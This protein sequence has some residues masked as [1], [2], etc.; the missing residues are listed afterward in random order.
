LSESLSA[1]DL[2]I[3]KLPR[4]VAIIMDGNGRWAT[5]RNLKRIEGHRRGSEVVKKIIDFSKDIGIEVLTLYAFSEENWH[6]PQEEVQAL[7]DI[8]ANYLSSEFERMVSEGLRLHTVG[9]VDK[10]PGKVQDIINAGKKVTRNNTGM[11]FNLALS[12]GSREE[13]VRAVREIVED[14]RRGDISTDDID[15]DLISSHL[16]T[17]D[18]PDPDL[19]IR[20][21]GEFRVSNFLLYQIAYTEIY[22]TKTLWPDFTEEEYTEILKDYAGRE[23]RFGRTGEQ[24]RQEG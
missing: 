23:R 14:V 1:Q 5:D 11:V 13:L 10:L 8:L 6:R 18:L 22:I 3:K 16:Y 9:R 15:E 2:G 19:L 4:H 24:V 20:T 12:Y 17:N 21:S 7:M